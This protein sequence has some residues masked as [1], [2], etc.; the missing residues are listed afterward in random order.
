MGVETPAK[1]INPPAVVVGG[2][3]LAE[4]VYQY[5]RG[6]IISER[7]VPGAE[8]SEVAL[9]ESLRISR[10][11]V[12]EAMGRLRSEGLVEV[13]PFRG[14]VVASLS[15]REFEE[16]YQ[17]R[18]ALEAM[19]V[20]LATPKFAAEPFEFIDGLIGDMEA[21]ADAADEEGFFTV[22][23]RFHRAILESA[24][25]GTLLEIYDRLI[26]RV[27]RYSHR[28]ATLRGDLASSVTEHRAIIEA[29]RRGVPDVA[30]RLMEEHIE[31]PLRKVQELTEAAWE[32]LSSFGASDG[33]ST[34][35]TSQANPVD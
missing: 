3:T 30:S 19:G 9:A 15:K 21:L 24:D 17:V 20:R 13:R 26:A 10:G 27:A 28:S 2:N 23:R 25:N 18:V 5:V 32:N 33:L 29:M 4:Q 11:P 34:T 16:A 6:E 8:L 22:N 35:T 31:I 12:R 7:L 14:A 1:V